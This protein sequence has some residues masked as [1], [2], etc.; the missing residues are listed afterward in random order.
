MYQATVSHFAS[1]PVAICILES[2]VLLSQ[3]NSPSTRSLVI[4]TLFRRNV[5]HVL[6]GSGF[7]RAYRPVELYS[8]L[9]STAI[10]F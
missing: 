7:P 6:A 3:L 4:T 8:T 5:E 10:I 1:L 9:C 2:F